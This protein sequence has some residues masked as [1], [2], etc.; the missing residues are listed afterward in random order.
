MGCPFRALEL[1]SVLF[2]SLSVGLF[3]YDEF[4]VPR[5]DCVT[6]ALCHDVHVPLCK[7]LLCVHRHGTSSWVSSFWV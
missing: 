3:V 7:D 4:I 1:V 5:N 2:S 6:Q